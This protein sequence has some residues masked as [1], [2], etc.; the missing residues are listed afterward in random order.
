MTPLDLEEQSPYRHADRPTVIVRLAYR[1]SQVDTEALLDTGATVCVFD[2]TLAAL[3]GIPLTRGRRV[4]IFGLD[5]TIRAARMMPLDLMVLPESA[6]I[7]LRQTEVGF[8]SAVDF[9]LSHSHRTIHLGL[10]RA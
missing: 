7:R 8:F 9:G 10:S 3:L 1:D 5:G 4:P 6:G 2:A